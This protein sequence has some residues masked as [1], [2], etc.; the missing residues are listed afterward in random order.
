MAVIAEVTLRG[1]TREQY[2]AVRQGTGWLERTPDGGLAHLTWWKGEACHNVDG[3]ESEAAFDA[4]GEQRL[5]PAMAALGIDVMPEVTFHPAHEIFTPRAGVV[6]ATATSNVTRNV[7]RVR[8]GYAAF[9]AGDIPAVLVMFADDLAWSVPDGLPTSG[10]Y[11]GPQGVAEF[12]T[13]LAQTYSELEVVP[14]RFIDAGDT[15][16]ATGRHRGRTTSGG[17]FEVPWMHLWTFRD[18]KATEFTEVFDTAPVTR[19]LEGSA[20]V[21]AILRR[22]FDEIINQGRLEVA[23]ELFAEDFVD[24]GPMG[25][26]AGREGFKQLVARWRDAVPDVHCEVDTVI[27]QGDLCAWLVRTTGTHTGEGLGF[28]ATGRRF[29]TVSANIGRFRDGRAAE[30]WAEQGMF[31]MLVQLGVL[32]APAA[33]VPSPRTAPADRPVAAGPGTS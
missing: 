18:G 10:V 25:D 8:S 2:D 3:W 16:V 32:P 29:A 17:A 19:A 27:G 20:G 28:P 12:F 5:R 33:A 9:A 1:I 11:R 13:K 31:P 23:D 24:H 26:I 21:E 14:E 7:D 15:V 6:A 30:H 22:M 4:F